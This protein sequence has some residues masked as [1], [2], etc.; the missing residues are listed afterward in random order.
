MCFCVSSRMVVL[1]AIML[2]KAEKLWVQ[3]RSCLVDIWLSNFE[4][5]HLGCWSLH[6]SPPFHL[7][8]LS[9][10]EPA[11]LQKSPLRLRTS[12]RPAASALGSSPQLCAP[13]L[14]LKCTSRQHV[15]RRL[16]LAGSFAASPPLHFHF[17]PHQRASSALKRYTRCQKNMASTVLSSQGVTEAPG[18]CTSNKA[19]VVFPM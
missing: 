16:R 1:S 11:D 7:N 8:S 3:F 19:A 15:P 13:L 9:E 5:S 10:E 14:K 6:F 12:P 17:S 4:I 18:L 2:P